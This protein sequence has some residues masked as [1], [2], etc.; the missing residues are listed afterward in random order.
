MDT[1]LFSEGISSP[2]T[3]RKENFCSKD[4]KNKNSSILAKDSPKQTRLPKKNNNPCKTL[5]NCKRNCSWIDVW[6]SVNGIKAT[7]IEKTI[8]IGEQ[9]SYQ[10]LYSKDCSIWQIVAGSGFHLSNR[11]GM[12]KNKSPRGSQV[13]PK[14]FSE[15]FNKRNQGEGVE[16]K[17]PKGE[18]W[19][20]SSMWGGSQP[21][22]S[23]YR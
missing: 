12:S 15:Y 18:V 17:W 3:H 19:K 1:W 22:T 2:G 4:V 23:P 7:W 13:R 6:N 14:G 21:K 10:N 8:S 9:L 5:G 11:W 20:K 16:I